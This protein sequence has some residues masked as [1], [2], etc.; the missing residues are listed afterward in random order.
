MDVRDRLA[1]LAALPLSEVLKLPEVGKE[2]I[3]M[4]DGVEYRFITWHDQVEGGGHRVFVSKHDDRILAGLSNV[5]Y[6]GFVMEGDGT[7]RA[8]TEEERREF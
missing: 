3:E 1:G 4:I 5:W 7:V 8:L 2:D 6:D